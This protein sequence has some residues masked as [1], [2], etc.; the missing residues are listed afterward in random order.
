MRYCL[1][2]LCLLGAGYAQ[3][4]T[5]DTAAPMLQPAPVV[6][7]TWVANAGQWHR[8]AAFRADAALGPIWVS[9]NG[10]V[11]YQIADD[12]TPWAVVERVGDGNGRVR[13]GRASGGGSSYFATDEGIH[14]RHFESIWVDGLFPRMQMELRAADRTV[15]K[16][17]HFDAHA[18]PERLWLGFRGSQTI[19]IG[20]DG[21]LRVASEGADLRFS[22]PIAFQEINGK[23]VDV[24][25][26]YVVDAKRDRY[27]F[28]LGSYERE[29]PLVI[30]PFVQSTYVGGG[31]SDAIYGMRVASNGEVIVAGETSSSDFPGIAGGAVPIYPVGNDR[32]QTMLFVARYSSDLRTRLQATY[33]GS[34]FI[35]TAHNFRGLAIQPDGSIVLAG[36]T[37]Q[38]VLGPPTTPL[39]GMAG[40]FQ[41]VSPI[42]STGGGT[43]G[44]LVRFSADLTVLRQ[45]TF[46]GADATLLFGVESDASGNVYFGGHTISRNFPGLGNGVDV[47]NAVFAARLNATLTGGYA[48]NILAHD[49][50]NFRPV[51]FRGSFARNPV[52]GDLYVGGE[53]AG[54]PG[55]PQNGLFVTRFPGNLGPPLASA[56]LSSPTTWIRPGYGNNALFHTWGGL[57][58]SPITNDV[59]LVGTSTATDVPVAPGVLQTTNAGLNDGVIWR[60]NAALS[61]QTVSYFGGGGQDVLFDAMFH[62]NG[63]LYVGGAVLSGTPGSAVLPAQSVGAIASSTGCVNSTEGCGFVARIAPTLTQARATTLLNAS[64]GRFSQNA[65]ARAPGGDV[66]VAGW[67][68]HNGPSMPALAGGAQVALGAFEEGFITRI[69]PDLAGESMFANGFE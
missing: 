8:D 43:V 33:Y 42:A 38:G 1:M 4:T 28:E 5:R 63:D 53:Q 11:V 56:R 30:D 51:L 47:L 39:P 25:V 54:G 45:A 52:T 2:A 20:E 14:T 35:S 7:T 6:E 49:G 15:E 57:A 41:P 32:P 58:I 69:T 3:A 26:A 44:F 23:R 31:G 68:R 48:V 64:E 24:E 59:V 66:Y 9:R 36:S 29:H 22:K 65:L 46:F 37:S 61:Q 27:R 62:P 13:S 55:D 17:L 10:E 12:Q 40:G 21:S 18:A 67:A 19:S 34:S 60:L 50:L 16:L